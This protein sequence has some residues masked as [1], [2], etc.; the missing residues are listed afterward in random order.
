[1]RDSDATRLGRMLELHV[2]ALL[3]EIPPAI[4]PQRRENGSTVH[5]VKYTLVRIV[6]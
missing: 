2:A 4:G 3:S 6:Q 1:M 5:R